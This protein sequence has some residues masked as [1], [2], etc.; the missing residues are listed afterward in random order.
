MSEP[1]IRCE[2]LGFTYTEDE[3]NTDTA[4]VEIPAL[5]DVNLSVYRGE[6]IA[7]LGHNGSGKSTLAKLLNLILVPTEGKVY[8]DGKDV[9]DENFSEDDLF[10]VRR[11]VGMVFQNPDNQLVATVVEEDVAFGPENLGLPREEIRRR[12]TDALNVVSMQNYANHAPHKLS[13]GQKQR[14]AI[15]GIIAM[16]PDVIIFDES[17]AML[18]PLGRAEVVRIMEKLNRE[19]GITVINITHYMEEAARADRVVVINDG[20]LILDGSAKEVFSDISLLHRI[21][22][23][24]PQGAELIHALRKDGFGIAGDSLT[25]EESVETLLAFLESYKS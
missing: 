14:I 24:A 21:G 6:Y 7:V 17:T 12:V 5:S 11:K 16:K 22:L 4:R 2:H 18:D 25:E 23:E 13:G 9:T 15:A 20:K 1:I 10:D 8:I 3:E 19:E